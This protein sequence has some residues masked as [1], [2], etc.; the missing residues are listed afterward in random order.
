MIVN[1]G[2]DYDEYKTYY[3]NSYFENLNL[4][5]QEPDWNVIILQAM[6]F[7]EFQDC[8]ALLDMLEYVEYVCKYK[9]DHETKFE[10]MLEW[11]LKIKLGIST[12]PLP[13]YTADNKKINLLDLYVVVKREDGHKNVTTNNLRVVISKDMGYDYG[14][15]E[16]MRIM[17]VMYLDVLVYY[18]KFKSTQ[19]KVFE[20]EIVKNNEDVSRSRKYS[21]HYD[22]VA[23]R[24]ERI[25]SEGSF[26]EEEEEEGDHYALFA[27]NDWHDMKKL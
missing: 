16:L 25:K 21:G 27:G 11:F 22:S 24:R 12:R 23:D 6:E 8:K 15:G 3:I 5:S 1:L 9:Y 18:Y 2:S 10:K 17:Y 20:N 26:P 14:D 7:H 19:L 13:P 4:S